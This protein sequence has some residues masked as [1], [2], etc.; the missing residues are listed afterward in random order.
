[1]A[2]AL[3][4]TG[5]AV[6]EQDGR[7]IVAEASAGSG[8]IVWVGGNLFYHAKA[9]AND[10]EADFLIGLLGPVTTSPAPSGSA[11][12]LDPERVSIRTSGASGAFVSASYHPKWA[13]R[14][15]D[16]SS[17]HVYYAGP[18]LMYVPLPRDDGVLTLEFGRGWADYAVWP[19]VIAGG[20]ICVWPLIARRRKD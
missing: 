6:L 19:P 4:A 8:R 7:P 1:V 12:Q 3:R 9:Y 11:E 2:T 15:S 16:G 18:G 5:R 14:W 10:V 17:R 20:L 13:A